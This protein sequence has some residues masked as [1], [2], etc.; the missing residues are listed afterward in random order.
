MIKINGPQSRWLSRALS[1]IKHRWECNRYGFANTLH[2]ATLILPVML[3]KNKEGHMALYRFNMPARTLGFPV[4]V[5][6]YVP[7]EAI[8]IPT[9]WLLHGAN[10]DDRE[11]LQDSSLLRYLQ[12]R[13]LAA[14]TVSVHNGFYVN[15][16]YGASYAD[17][18]EGEWIDA[19]RGLFPCL[20]RDRAKNF[21][22]GASMGG[23]GALRLVMNRLDL[24]C[25]VGSFAGSIEMPTIVERYARGI[26]PGGE[27]FRWAFDGYENM[28]RNSNDVIYL[29]RQCEDKDRLPEIYMVIGLDDFG[30][31]LNMIARDDLL[32]AGAKVRWVEVPGSHS[33]DCW[34]PALPAFLNWLESKEAS[35]C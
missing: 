20:S 25:K 21:V 7:E 26:Q 3:V 12:G 16:A 28:V 22:A 4:E 1:A 14:V 5:S 29:A 8:N 11:W 9:L 15:M 34:D 17:F 33:F 2:P 6:V 32:A 23:F 31:A 18:L 35:P 30:Y 24:F 13:R 27:D 10:N 19:V